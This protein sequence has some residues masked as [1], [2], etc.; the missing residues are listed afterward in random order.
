MLIAEAYCW[1]GWPKGTCQN[2]RSSLMFVATPPPQPLLGRV[3]C[4]R[5]SRARL[6]SLPLTVCVFNGCNSSRETCS[7][8]GVSSAGSQQGME[9]D[10]SSLI[11]SAW[12][13]FDSL[14][15]GCL[16]FGLVPIRSHVVLFQCVRR[17]RQVM[18]IENVAALLSKQASCR[19]VFNYIHQAGAHELG[20]EFVAESPDPGVCE[21]EYEFALVQ[22]A[23]FACGTTSGGLTRSRSGM[24]KGFFTNSYI[25]DFVFESLWHFTE[26]LGQ[27]VSRLAQ[28]LFGT[29]PRPWHRVWIL[30]GACLQG[31][32]SVIAHSE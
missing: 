24:H 28:S 32:K 21:E 7:G 5:V 14:S 11:K 29:S 16:D 13:C 12:E 17:C 20:C 9:D 3:L 27:H 19:D 6:G 31:L 1:P 15:Q 18:V 10:R 25:N 26:V 23:A 2:A 30:W 8:Q 22:L 4:W